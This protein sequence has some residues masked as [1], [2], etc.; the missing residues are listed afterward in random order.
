[1]V[2][3]GHDREIEMYVHM[4][5]YA[6]MFR[7]TL[8]IIAQNWKQPKYPSGGEWINKLRTTTQQWNNNDNKGR[9]VA[10]MD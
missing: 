7:S 10:A 2:W 4:K 5:T 1:M 3:S 8:F 9:A 6:W